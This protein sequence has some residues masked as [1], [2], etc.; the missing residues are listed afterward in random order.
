MTIPEMAA[1]AKQ[2]WKENY[3]ETYKRMVKNGDL[4]KEA[5]ACA[6]LTMDE[7]KSLMAVKYTEAEAWEASRELFIL[8]NPKKH[9]RL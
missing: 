7:M 1:T 3:P 9:Y 2:H 4:E 6:K 8:C 5:V